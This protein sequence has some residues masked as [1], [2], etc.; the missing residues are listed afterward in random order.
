[1]K[2]KI[3]LTAIVLAIIGYFLIDGWVTILEEN[4]V[5]KWQNFTGLI[6]FVPLPILLFW[7]H[8]AAVL[9]TGIYLLLGLC[10]ALSLTAEISTGSVTIAGLTISGFNWL[11]LG[12]LVLYFILHITILI[13]M[14]LDY[15]ES[16][17]KLRKP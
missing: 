10:R 4:Y 14:Q 11:S 6:F 5:A 12:L 7:N 17:T 15:K 9:G 8:R 2:M 16:K 1:M 13:D 3:I